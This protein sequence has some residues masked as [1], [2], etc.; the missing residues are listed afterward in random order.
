MIHA[1]LKMG[2][3][4]LLRVAAPVERYDTPEL[5]ALIDDM[6]ETMAHAQGVGLA[7]PQIG[8]D[9]QLV[10]FGF[11]RNDRYPDAP[12]VPRT[13]LCNPV[14]EPLS[15]E[16][17]DGW[18]GCLSVPG[19]RG[20]VPRYRHIRYSGYD[21]AGQRIEREAEGF[22][23]RVVQHECDHL[24]GRLYPTRI[25]DLTKFGYTEVLFPEM[26]PNAD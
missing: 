11:E 20:L 10:I 24:I 7:A 2:D 6:F 12:A 17:E 19:L 5:R 21:P 22:H 26:D 25:R 3:P 13:I 14:I 9:L 23:A 16:M 18:E 15:G 8:V 1:I 4:R